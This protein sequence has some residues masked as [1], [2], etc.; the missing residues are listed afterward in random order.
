MAQTNAT[1][2]VTS[3]QPQQQQL[4]S[5]SSKP[6][7]EQSKRLS[8]EKVGNELERAIREPHQQP[9]QE[10]LSAVQETRTAF[11]FLGKNN[12]QEA[13]SALERALG[14]IEIVLNNYP[15]VATV[16]VSVDVSLIDL[17]A[18][19]FTLKRTI[20]QI[21]DYVE[22][23]R[24]QD[25]RRRL[26]GLASEIDIITVHL[27]IATY[28]DAIR[29]ASKLLE[30]G[31]AQDARSELLEALN[32]LMLEEK[33]I[34]LPIVRAQ[35]LVEEVS[36]QVNEN[37]VNKE[38]AN[39]LLEDA[40]QQLTFAE[41]L[42]YGTRVEDFA[43]LNN[44]IKEIKEKINQDQ[45]SKSFLNKLKEKLQSLRESVSGTPKAAA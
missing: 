21:V 1:Q 9:V 27:P 33:P 28:P 25:A 37:K 8:Q 36:K 7:G 30:Q 22:D 40:N 4:S 20:G 26:R 42:G 3:E 32:T 17:Y 44:A 15:D 24:L 29:S 39:N 19:E 12:I 31:N 34:P 13:K 2:K 41:T 5:D 35:G 45:E 18:D 10:A 23:G 11:D 16:P 38:Q 6:L 14:K 43:D